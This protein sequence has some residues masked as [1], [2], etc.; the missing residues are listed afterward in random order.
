LARS[1]PVSLLVALRPR[2]WVKNLFVAAPLIFAK[3]LG[4]A[5]SVFLGGLAVAAFSALSSA[6]YLVNDVVDREKDRAHPTKCRRPIAAGEISSSLA[7]GVGIGL[8]TAGLAVA[9]WLDWRFGAVAGVYLGLNV[10]YSFGLKEVAWI[11]VSIIAAGFLLRVLGGAY[12]VFVPP[13]PWL[14]VCTGLL[15]ALLGFGKR[16][17]ELGQA[18]Q[19]G[20]ALDETRG[21]L[22]RYSARELKI[23]LWILAAATVTSYAFYTQSAHT[24][25]FFGTRQL[26][27]TAPFPALGI[28]RFLH[29]VTRHGEA[30]SPTD[31]ILRDLPFMANLAVWGAVVLFII[32]F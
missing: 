12:A 5:D 15:A 25:A 26:L 29:L 28:A 31:A 1:F 30:D 6:V 22:A 32:Y 2:Q 4:D 23:V 16:A 18:T 27:W 11:D 10:V 13:S 14:L 24:V 7:V 3:R 19:A 8:A 20:R 21:V 9:F 17:H